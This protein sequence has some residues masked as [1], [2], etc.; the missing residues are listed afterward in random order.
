LLARLTIRVTVLA[1]F[2][3]LAVAGLGLPLVGAATPLWLIILACRS[4]SIG[5]VINPLLQALTEPA[6]NP[7]TPRPTHLTSPAGTISAVDPGLVVDP[8]HPNTPD[9]PRSPNQ[10]QSFRGARNTGSTSTTS[11]SST[12]T[13]GALPPPGEASL[14]GYVGGGLG[15]GLRV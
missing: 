3:V 6:P 4:V 7:S 10:P 13:T 1:G 11:T 2:T 8:V 12:S 14:L 5:L 9:Q 15:D